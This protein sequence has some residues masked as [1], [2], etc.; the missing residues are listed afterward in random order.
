MKTRFK[1]KKQLND[2]EKKQKSIDL[3]DLIS[4]ENEVKKEIDLLASKGK[5]DSKRYRYLVKTRI[6]LIRDINIIRRSYGE[7]LG[8]QNSHGRTSFTYYDHENNEYK[9]I[10][11][12]HETQL[13]NLE[14][15][16]L[17]EYIKEEKIKSVKKVAK[18]ILTNRQYIIF[19][20][21][22]F[23]DLTQQE[24]ADLMGIPRPNVTREL[25]VIIKKIRENGTF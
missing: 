14:Q 5:S 24:I 1:N 21:Y 12:A 20:L 17:D 6:Q 25:G 4:Y 7:V 13:D 15:D 18:N 8:K 2:D 16:Q 11:E 23:N 22:Y 10:L 19:E 3:K 9:Y